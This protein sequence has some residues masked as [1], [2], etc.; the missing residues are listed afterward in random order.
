MSRFCG[1]DHLTPMERAAETEF[2]AVH[3]AVNRHPDWSLRDWADHWFCAPSHVLRI[4]RRH[5][6]VRRK[7]RGWT[8]DR[9]EARPTEEG[10]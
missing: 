7:G 2:A 3:A 4:F 6:V 8:G 10:D 1:C 9:N 5:G